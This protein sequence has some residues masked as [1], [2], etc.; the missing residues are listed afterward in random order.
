[1]KKQNVFT[2]SNQ[3]RG[4]QMP[5]KPRVTINIPQQVLAANSPYLS[6]GPHTAH[7][8]STAPPGA[9][10]WPLYANPF[11]G[12]NMYK[13]FEG[14]CDFTMASAKSGLG[15]GEK[16]AFYLYEKF[17][18]WSKKWFTHIF[19]FLCMFLYSLAGAY[20]LMA[21]EG[22]PQKQAFIDFVK[23]RTDFSQQLYGLARSEHSDNLTSWQVEVEK[24]MKPFM[25]DIT[26]LF[27]KGYFDIDR[28]E[29]RRPPEW[30]N[31]W[32]AMFFCG[33]VFTTI[34][35]GHMT[36]STTT[37]RAV[38]I[39]YA[40]IGIPMFLILLADF[41]KL[42]TRGIKFMW[43]YVRRLYYTGSC[44][45]VRK[46]AQV[47]DVLR[48]MNIAYEIATFRR[49]SMMM[50]APDLEEGKEGK[51]GQSP[52]Q[53]ALPSNVETP[54]TPMPPEIDDPIDD[55]FN[56]PISLAFFLLLTYIFCGA[57]VY[58]YYE[59]WSFFEACY[60]VFISMSTIGF[61]DLVPRHR[62]SMMMSI[63]YFVFG[64]ALTSMCINVIQV[65]LSDSF[66]QATAK[67]GATIGLSIAEEEAA[68]S[69][70]ETPTEDD[71]PSVHSG[72]VKH[73]NPTVVIDEAPPLPPKKS[74]T[75]AKDE[76]D[77][78]SKKPKK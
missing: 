13:Q 64:L 8:N 23:I 42:F 14:F 47:Q 50:K 34:G 73:N 9:P 29:N 59:D 76:N 71:I 41:G 62:I 57:A 4:R 6:T 63:L 24:A 53:L 1:M 39:V 17:S 45:K 68:R 21:C 61:G 12:A 11:T 16:F 30:N 38:T 37:G 66:R 36:P 7:S 58:T 60:F 3:P 77:K 31:I 18:T 44:R 32:S 48:G 27:K 2:I 49:P 54:E 10:Q 70:N 35:Y 40:I 22:P 52:S 43:A 15:F 75:V 65:K 55:E 33:T 46:Q 78:S 19:L 72:S 69:Q 28:S 51:E 67:I 56:L 26:D 74:E 20:I 5:P 25:N